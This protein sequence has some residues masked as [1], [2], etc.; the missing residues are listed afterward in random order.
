VLP[1]LVGC[2]V[3]TLKKKRAKESVNY[4]L[5]TAGFEPGTSDLKSTHLLPPP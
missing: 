5:A 4:L 1:Q 2:A 3:S